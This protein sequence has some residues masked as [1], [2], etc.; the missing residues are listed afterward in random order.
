MD[1]LLRSKLK[2]LPPWNPAAFPVRSA[3]A[4]FITISEQSVTGARAVEAALGRLS[5]AELDEYSQPE[6]IPSTSEAVA[7]LAKKGAQ[8]SQ[9]HW[10]Q[11]EDCLL[12]LSRSK[13]AESL[14]VPGVA[15]EFVIRT[16]RSIWTVRRI[17]DPGEILDCPVYFE[18]NELITHSRRPS[19]L[20]A[21]VMR[22]QPQYGLARL[23]RAIAVALS[24]LRLRKDSLRQQKGSERV[25]VSGA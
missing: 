7:F 1:L 9:Y 16:G 20:R 12:L 21:D 10:I 17:P 25:A 24:P 18:R 19:K 23:G 4:R 3:I 8:S 2:A 15:F 6:A 13:R 14:G 22:P 11:Q 5:D